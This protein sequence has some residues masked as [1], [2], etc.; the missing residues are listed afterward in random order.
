M[1]ATKRTRPV[2][3]ELAVAAPQETVREVLEITRFSLVFPVHVTLDAGL[4]A[5]TDRA[6]G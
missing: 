6:P 5:F 1:I 3:G 2:G 4:Q